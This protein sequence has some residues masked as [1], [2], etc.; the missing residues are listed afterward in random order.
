M[1]A[2]LVAKKK[3]DNRVRVVRK[4]VEGAAVK[5]VAVVEVKAVEEAKALNKAAVLV[6]AVALAVAA[7]AAA[8]Q[9]EFQKN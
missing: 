5:V 8:V 1:Q 4:A 3:K 6:V 7:A 9:I 2:L